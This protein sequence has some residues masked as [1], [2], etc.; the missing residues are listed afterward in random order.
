MKLSSEVKVAYSPA[1]K[2]VF[3]LLSRKE[4]TTTSL[5]ERLYEG[6]GKPPSFHAGHSVSGTLRSLA[7]KIEINSENFA[8]MRSARRGPHPVSHWL[9]PLKRRKK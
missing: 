1:E 8:L 6:R 2:E 4:Q 5:V 7:K 9:V 3:S